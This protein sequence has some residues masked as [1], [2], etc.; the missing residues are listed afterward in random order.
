MLGLKKSRGEAYVETGNTAMRQSA[1]TEECLDVCGR[2]CVCVCVC[3]AGGVP[4]VL[5]S[6][7]SMNNVSLRR[8]MHWRILCS[9]SLI[10]PPLSESIYQT[11]R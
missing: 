10:F 6:S 5:Q 4:G 8:K 11:R 2:V 7:P 1:V 9:C 3:V